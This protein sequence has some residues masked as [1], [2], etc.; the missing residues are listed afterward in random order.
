MGSAGQEE[1][2]FGIDFG[3]TN[4]AIA[5]FQPGRQVQLTRFHFR[6]E[7]MPACRSVLDSSS[8]RLLTASATSMAFLILK[9]LNVT[10]MPKKKAAWFSRSNPIFPVA[11]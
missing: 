2:F 3:T 9:R 4:S 5:M 1:V 7:E 6:G 11:L 10:S 8:R